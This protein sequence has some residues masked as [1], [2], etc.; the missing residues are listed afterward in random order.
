MNLH[1]PFWPNLGSY[2]TI[3][4]D[5]PWP[6]RWSGG[7]GGRRARAVPMAYKTMTL[8]AIY[9]L[10]VGELVDVDGAHLYLWVTPELH[11]RGVGV[12]VAEAW[13]FAVVGEI[14]W[15]KRNFGM[16]AFPR[17][18]HEPLL[19]CRRGRLS[20]ARTDVGS[21]HDW[22]TPYA[23]GNGGKVHSAKPDASIDLVESASPGPYLELF[24]RRA[25]FGWDYWGD[26]SLGTAEM[27]EVAP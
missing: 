9:E 3:I 20:F 7:A 24:A 1:R 14:I 22:P 27:L 11:R 15:R 2:R 6:I 21:V 18:Q 5:P 17:P 26:E 25:R 10:P 8:T 4:A 19:V 16:G 13:G 12:E 23:S